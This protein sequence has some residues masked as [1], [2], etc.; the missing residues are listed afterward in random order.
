MR[1]SIQT[2]AAL[3]VCALASFPAMST[4]D[5]IEV[6]T[7]EISAP[8]TFGL[9]QHLNY[10]LD[11]VKTAEY[12]GQMTSHRV[13]QATPEFYYGIS[14]TLEAG[15]YLPLAFTPTTLNCWLYLKSFSRTSFISM[16]SFSLL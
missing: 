16:K 1:K 11:G 2:L 6:Y 10:T 3:M 15:V 4:P 5:E 7:D 12:A 8:G 13:M 9:E 14:D